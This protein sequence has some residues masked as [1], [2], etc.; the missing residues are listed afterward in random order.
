MRDYVIIFGAAVRSDGRPSGSLRHRIEGALAWAARHPDALFIPTGGIGESGFAEAEVIQD[1]LAKGGIAPA[2]IV[3]ELQARDTLESVRLCDAI[4][5]ERGDCGR[6]ICCTS[7]YH[8]P[9]CGLLFRILGYKVVL[10]DMPQG[11]GRLSRGALAGLV[12]KEVIA[13][14]YDALLLLVMRGRRGR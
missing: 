11:L 4:L 10:P 13:T 9:R 1:G 3:P 14:P 2:R 5:R 7:T 6:V 12:L 8:Q